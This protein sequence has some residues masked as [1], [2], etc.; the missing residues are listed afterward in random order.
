VHDNSH[1]FD[2][3]SYLN[4]NPKHIHLDA[5]APPACRTVTKRRLGPR[6]C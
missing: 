6:E 5:H 4:E 1:T 3:E 2:D